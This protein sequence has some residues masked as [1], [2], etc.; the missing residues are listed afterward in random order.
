MEPIS[1]NHIY[2]MHLI[3]Q[4]AARRSCLV[5]AHYLVNQAACDKLDSP[6]GPFAGRVQ[7][8]I[9]LHPFPRPALHD[10]RPGCVPLV[11]LGTERARSV[12]SVSGNS[13]YGGYR[14]TMTAIELGHRHIIVC[15]NPAPIS[16]GQDLFIEGHREAMIENGLNVHEQTI[17]D[18]Q[19]TPWNDLTGLR[20][21]LVQY[22]DATCIL[23]GSH[24]LASNLLQVAELAGIDIPGHVSL[25]CIGAMVFPGG[26]SVSGITFRSDGAVKRAF[27]MLEELIQTG[28]VHCHRQMLNPLLH[29]GETLAPP[30]ETQD[31]KEI[32]VEEQ[33]A[34]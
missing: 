22:K 33:Q 34:G 32:L 21:Y 29:P 8:V 25:A 26:R 30:R 12:P 31:R 23:A 20:D 7:G 17:R 13:W 4:E 3:V 10:V 6:D 27:D 11:F 5:E 15:A 9:S 2:L 24:E 18:S 14:L 19:A 1:Q 16:Y 28:E